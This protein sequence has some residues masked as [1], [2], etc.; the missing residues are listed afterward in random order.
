MPSPYG[1]GGWAD[2]RN[3]YIGVI[4]QLRLNWSFDA[5][6]DFAFNSRALAS[7]GDIAAISG[8]L[9]Q[10]GFSSTAEADLQRIIADGVGQ[11]D[12]TWRE[13]QARG[14]YDDMHSGNAS[15]FQYYESLAPSG[16]P[17]LPAEACQ[18]DQAYCYDEPFLS[19]PYN[20]ARTRILITRGST[21]NCPSSPIPSPAS[22]WT[23][24]AFT[25]NGDCAISAS[26][27]ASCCL[28][29][30]RWPRLRFPCRSGLSCQC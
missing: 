14:G 9:M 10:R 1:Q 15:I 2:L 7:S 27:R 6:S 4:Q 13:M 28:P 26:W 22:P 29:A 8:L 12:A 16:C 17:P 19:D 3:A 20:P 18:A 5:Y 23:R 11:E 24:S 25:R 30:A 21:G